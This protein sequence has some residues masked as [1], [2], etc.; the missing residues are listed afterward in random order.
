M[1]TL[2]KKYNLKMEVLLGGY[3]SRTTTG[4]Q[5]EKDYSVVEEAVGLFQQTL[6]IRQDVLITLKPKRD[7]FEGPEGT[8]FVNGAIKKISCHVYVH[9]YTALLQ[10][11]MTIAHEMVHAWQHDNNLPYDHDGWEIQAT[12]MATGMVTQIWADR[13][14]DKPESM[15]DFEVRMVA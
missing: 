11:L 3:L 14:P 8:C 1:V 10:V 2:K 5:F 15:I 6:N 12:E 4:P 7:V 13:H 9:K